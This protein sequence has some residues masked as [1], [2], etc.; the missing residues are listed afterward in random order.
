MKFLSMIVLTFILTTSLWAKSVLIDVQL[1]PSGSFQIKTNKI[2]GKIKKSG[3][4]L[5]AKKITVRSKHLKS[6]IDLRDDHI[7]KR[8]GKKVVITDAK[9]KN[10]KGTAKITFNGVTKKIPFTY[11]EKG[12]EV[13]ISFKLNLKKFKVKDLTYMGVGAKDIIKVRA[14]VPLK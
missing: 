14:S 8:I 7:R 12:K 1:S 4:I 3:D 11:K 13:A 6:G 10:A 2:K 9:G 5:S